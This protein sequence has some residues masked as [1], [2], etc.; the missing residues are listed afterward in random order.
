MSD[1]ED[2]DLTAIVEAGEDAVDR[3]VHP[4]GIVPVLQCVRGGERRA[5]ASKPRASGGGASTT[6]RAEERRGNRGAEFN[7]R[8][9]DGV[10]G[11]APTNGEASANAGERLTAR[12]RET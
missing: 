1:G 7:W 4:S 6:T 10:G 11:T 2:E 3:S 12:A 5:R 8:G 9:A